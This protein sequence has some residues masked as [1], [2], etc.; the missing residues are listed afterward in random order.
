MTAVTT[1]LTRA[2]NIEASE[3]DVTAMCAKHNAR[4]SAIESLM[5][6][7]TRVVLNTLDDATVIR[8]A[9]KSQLI[10]GPVRRTRWVRNG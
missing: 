9:Y 10:T 7:G 5:S 8:K 1:T 3:A 2:I 6:G 4:V